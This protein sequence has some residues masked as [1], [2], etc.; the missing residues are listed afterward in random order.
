MSLRKQ[1]SF[2][3]TSAACALGLCVVLSAACRA[4]ENN[5]PSGGDGGS[6]AQGPAGPGPGG[7]GGTGGAG[8]AGGSGGSGGGATC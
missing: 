6:G 1:W 2:L 5:N 7:A 3:G 4:E 8:G